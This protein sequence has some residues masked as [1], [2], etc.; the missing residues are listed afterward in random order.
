MYYHLK[1][2]HTQHLIFGEVSSCHMNHGFPVQFNKPIGQL[3]FG[4][5]GNHL[6]LVVNEIFTDGGPKE[7]NVTIA[8]EAPSKEVCGTAKESDCRKNRV[9]QKVF[10]SKCPVISGSL[11]NQDESIAGAA[12]QEEVPKSNI[13]VHGNKVLVFCPIKRST[14]VGFPYNCIGTQGRGEFPTIQQFTV[15]A[16]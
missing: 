2:K 13:H 8:V 6:G 3:P 9:R 5:C 11:V 1:P 14:T 7:F 10:Q 4:W 16:D 12:N 15:A